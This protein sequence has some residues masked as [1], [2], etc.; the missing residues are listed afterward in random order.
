MEGLIPNKVHFRDK[1]GNGGNDMVMDLSAEQIIS[2]KDKLNKLDCEKVLSTGLWIVL[3]QYL[4]VQPW[5]VS[6]NLTQDF[7]NVV[8]SWIMLL[9]LPRY[10][11]KQKILGEIGGMIGKY[12]R[13][14]HVKEI[15]TFKASEHNTGDESLLTGL[16]PKSQNLAINKMLENDKTYGSNGAASEL[17]VGLG[18]TTRLANGNHSGNG[19]SRK[20]IKSIMVD[21]VDSKTWV[22]SHVLLRETMNYL[23][24]IISTNNRGEIC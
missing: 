12:G 15:C 17:S 23:A 6:F 8:I 11:Y 7:L 19:E 22:I 2:W 4:T 1:D 13:N 10:L 20:N 9:G 21:I 5:T 3:G 24:E 14:E 18:A 16:S